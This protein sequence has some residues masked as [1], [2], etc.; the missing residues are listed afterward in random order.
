MVIRL[1]SAGIRL[2][3]FWL[4]LGGALLGGVFFWLAPPMGVLVWI[5]AFLLFL[6]CLFCY[7]TGLE[8]LID[9]TE[10]C[11]RSGFVFPCLIRIPLR[12]LFGVVRRASPLS[13]ALGCQS[14]LL[15]AGGGLA[16]LLPALSMADA[17]AITC[18]LQGGQP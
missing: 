2:A 18:L 9:E 8:I 6:Y 3:G 4:F 1:S 5:L 14:L 13:L 15:Y 10:L 16:C 7:L 12:A 17:D 11:I